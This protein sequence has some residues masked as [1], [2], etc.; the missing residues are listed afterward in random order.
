MLA[1]S[2]GH[3]P[4]PPDPRPRLARRRAAP[5]RPGLRRAGSHHATDGSRRSSRDASPSTPRASSCL[6][7]TAATRPGV[8]PSPPSS[9]PV[10]GPW[11]RRPRRGRF[12]S[13]ARSTDPRR[14]PLHASSPRLAAF[15][16]RR[17]A[18]S[19]HRREPRA[20]RGRSRAAPDI[21]DHQDAARPARPRRAVAVGLRPALG[22]RRRLARSASTRSSCPR[23]AGDA[24]RHGPLRARALRGPD[25]HRARPLRLPAARRARARRSGPP[26][27]VQAADAHRRR[28]P[29]D[30]GAGPA[31]ARGPR[32]RTAAGRCR[33]PSGPGGRRRAGGDAGR[34]GPRS[35]TFAAGRPS[36]RGMPQRPESVRRFGDTSHAMPHVPAPVDDGTAVLPQLRNRRSQA[37]ADP[38]AGPDDRPDPRRQ[39]Q[40]RP[41]PRRGRHGRGLR[42]RA[43]ARHDQA[44]GRGQDAA[45]AP[46]A[47][48]EDQGALRARGR[49][50]RRARAPEHHPGLRLRHDRR[51]HPLHR[52]G[53][54]PGQEPG[55]RTSR[56]RAR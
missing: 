54:P 7:R 25:A 9:S 4:H 56:R 20:R 15:G 26:L 53:V 21:V 1:V 45:P 46:L 23:P 12:R 14:L 31:R 29:G 22:P 33:G 47:R 11:R 37:G 30:I 19:H 35:D 24:P 38:G 17:R 43:A 8:P 16:P 6:A 13:R 40:G 27:R 32:D 49:H 39:V 36:N 41:P 50:H 52:D 5:R 42:G 28:L 44:Q 3:R 48:P 34:A 2:P 18:A 10:V 55:R 51:G